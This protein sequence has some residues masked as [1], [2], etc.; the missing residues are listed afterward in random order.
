MDKRFMSWAV[1]AVLISAAPALADEPGGYTKPHPPQTG[2]QVYR[3]VC[4]A[5]HM[6]NGMGGVGAARIPALANNPRLMA[7]LYPIDMVIHGRG[8]MPY[9]TDSL[10]PAQVAEVITYVRTH[11]GNHY[12]QPVTEA[13]VKAE[14]VPAPKSEH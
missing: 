13:D 12:A 7:P 14:W 2:E 8:A 6:A 5:C 9:V 4:Q 3:Q 11:F 1:A 10:T